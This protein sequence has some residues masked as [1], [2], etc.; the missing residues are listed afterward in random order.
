MKRKE[1]FYSEVCF[2]LFKKSEISVLAMG[3][4]TI[5]FVGLKFIIL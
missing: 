4:L 5:W 1:F 2:L 3:F